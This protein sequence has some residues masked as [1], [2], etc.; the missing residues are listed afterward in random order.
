MNII[1]VDDDPISRE[2]LKICIDRTEGNLKLVGSYSGIRDAMAALK[3][4]KNID[5]ILL[6]IE[7]PEINGIDF[8]NTFKEAPQVIVISSKKDY[9]ADAFNNDVVDYIVKPVNYDRFIKAV[10]KVQAVPTV[11]HLHHHGGGADFI[12]VRHKGRLQR[13]AMNDIEYAEANADYVNIVTNNEK[14]V[15]H[16][17]MKNI[18]AKFPSNKFVRAHRS[19]IVNIEKANTIEENTLYLGDKGIPIG[20]LYKEQLLNKLNLI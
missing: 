12:F 1:I 4:E 7:M 3:E 14:Y 18:E 5:L 11:S 9:A 6:D 17:S 15:V 10:K 8:L 13:V 20:R 2:L 16:S 19:F